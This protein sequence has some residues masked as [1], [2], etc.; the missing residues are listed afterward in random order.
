MAKQN[1]QYWKKRFEALEDA[2]NKKGQS[3][4][5]DVEE[6]YVKAQ[7]T[8]EAKIRVWYQRFADNNN[9]T[10]A[11]ARKMLTAKE[12]K[13][14][15]WDVKD[16]IKYGQENALNGEWMKQLENASTKYHISRLESL[17]IQTQQAVEEL[18]GNQLDGVDKL[19]RNI[20]TEGYYHTAYEI[21]KG[22][23]IGWDIASIDNNQLEKVISKPWAADGKNF[24]DRIW[25]NKSKLVNEL[26]THLTQTIMTGKSPDNAIREISRKF[27]TSK[28]N[29]GKL[30]M[31][32]SAFFSSASQGDCF[33][34]LDV[35]KFEVV[36]TLDSHTSEICQGLDGH[37]FEMKDYQPG[38]TA[39]PF[40]VWCRSTTVPRF[41]DNF[42]ERAARGTDGKTY[43]VQDTMKYPEWKKTF[44][45]GGSKDSLDIVHHD[46]MMKIESIVGQLPKLNSISSNSDR[47]VFAENLIDNLGIDRTNISINIQ[48][49]RDRG[50]CSF[51][52]AKDDGTCNYIQYMLQKGDDRNVNYQIK[53]A[54]HESYHLSLQGQKW[55]AVINGKIN[56]KWIEIEETFA[57]AASHYAS[58]LYGIED[59]SPSYPEKL[60]STLPRLKQL[61]KYSECKTLT[62][63]GEIAWADRLSGNS[64]KW[65]SF[66]DD[67][68]SVSFD[69]ANYYSQYYEHI[70]ANADSL[71]NKMLENAPGNITYKEQMMQ[72]FESSMKKVESGTSISKLQGNEKYIFTNMLINA[73]IKEGVK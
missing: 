18:Y 17:K 39:N 9:I 27:N 26:H 23:N 70:K 61:P 38:V 22:F 21:Q 63:F 52:A 6:Q 40:H 16:Y 13:E 4:Y 71:M 2:T 41:D 33:N 73:M 50:A 19:A 8:I 42:T 10:M 3:L 28:N 35:E 5:A 30:I 56:P 47:K 64:G 53:T 59:L 62:D 34:E 68:F 11:E 24:S 1:E 44:V 58:K 54:F 25:S 43:Y 32:E 67:V 69:E 36:A 55:D 45:D 65:A 20:Y 49:M 48:S 51:Y 37:V 66:Y 15:K 46:D 29:A 72:E 31:T 57:E 14:F 7:R 60:V 12:L